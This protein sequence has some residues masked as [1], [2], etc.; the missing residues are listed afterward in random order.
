MASAHSLYQLFKGEFGDTQVQEEGGTEEQKT[1][2]EK[3]TKIYDCI[4][5]ML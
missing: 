1:L 2:S 5:K 3:K 4:E